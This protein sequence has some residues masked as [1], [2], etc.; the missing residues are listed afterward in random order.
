ME[1]HRSS[2]IVLHEDRFSVSY[3]DKAQDCLCRVTFDLTRKYHVLIDNLESLH[4]LFMTTPW[5][6]PD[7]QFQ[8][9]VPGTANAIDCQI[10]G[11]FRR[12]II[13]DDPTVYLTLSPVGASTQVDYGSQLYRVNAGIPNLGPYPLSSART[14]S[15]EGG[16]WFF[17]LTPVDESRFLYPPEIQNDSQRFTHH[18]LLK[19]CDGGGFS[20]SSAREALYTL[21]TFLS[22]CAERWIAP[23]LIAGLGESGTIAM[24]EWGT[25]LLD[26][27]EGHAGWL[28]EY[29]GGTMADV[30]PGFSTLMRDPDWKRTI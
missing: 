13:G 6:G 20:C 3:G 18:L 28:D 29:H 10:F 21:S 22:F 5:F 26:P 25:A 19:R 8:V 11:S 9:L 4:E 27:N 7:R 1:P 17:E 2:G 24:E 14:I 30:F 16:T 15:V 23:V 12:Q